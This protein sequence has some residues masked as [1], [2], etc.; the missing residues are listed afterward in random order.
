MAENDPTDVIRDLASAPRP[1][2]P[3]R[4][5]FATEEL[6][7]DAWLDWQTEAR[8]QA[9]ATL[10]AIRS[11]LDDGP[12]RDGVWVP[13]DLAA[14]TLLRMAVRN[15]LAAPEGSRF[16]DQAELD[17]LD[18]MLG[19]LDPMIAVGTPNASTGEFVG[20]AARAHHYLPP[21]Y[22]EA[23][24]LDTGDPVRLVVGQVAGIVEGTMSA[25]FP[26]NGGA[27]HTLDEI[28]VTLAASEQVPAAET[29]R[30]VTALV[31][32]TGR[33]VRAADTPAVDMPEPVLARLAARMGI[34]AT[35]LSPRDAPH[36]DAAG[37]PGLALGR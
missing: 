14:V 24:N 19:G 31:A 28:A 33:A 2:V 20:H 11:I 10:E 18:R 15:E 3:L 23:R 6:F 21:G 1:P 32:D 16:F 34:R 27:E 25:A 29:V 12:G 9:E 13:R 26:I 5:Q 30:R 35:Q 22:Y 7:E 17:R 4:A 8:E 37:E 36:L